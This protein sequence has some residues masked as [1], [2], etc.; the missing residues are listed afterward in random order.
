MAKAPFQRYT[1]QLSNKP[2]GVSKKTE[3]GVPSSV[4][5]STSNYLSTKSPG[6][7]VFSLNILVP[8]AFWGERGQGYPLVTLEKEHHVVLKC[9]QKKSWDDFQIKDRLIVSQSVWTS[10]V[11]IMRW[12]LPEK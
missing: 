11:K 3:E 10:K 1:I 4:Y 2:V 7:K 5:Q 9:T 6:P 12:S 8:P